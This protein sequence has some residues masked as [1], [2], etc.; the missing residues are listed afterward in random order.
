MKSLPSMMCG[1]SSEPEPDHLHQPARQPGLLEQLDAAQRDEGRLAVGLQ[2]HAVARRERRKRVADAQRERVVP[3]RDDAHHADR[4]V[5]LPRLGERQRAPA[6]ARLE[7][8]LGGVRVVARHDRD[9]EH[10]LERVA[11][12]LAGL[13]LEQVEQLLLVVERQ[14]VVAQEDALALVEAG[15]RPLACAVRGRS[16]A[17]RT[18]AGPQRGTEPSGPP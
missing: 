2:H 3:G 14:V 9:V 1:P 15:P 16:I 8:L 10:L 7:V 18:S 17:V 12:R 5:V 13:D 11:A 4:V 6:P